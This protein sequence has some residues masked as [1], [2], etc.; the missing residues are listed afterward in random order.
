MYKSLHALVVGGEVTSP[1]PDDQ[2]QQ[3]HL[4]ELPSLLQREPGWVYLRNVLEG[5]IPFTK[6][7]SGS[8]LLT[9][10]A[11]LLILHGRDVASGRQSE[12]RLTRVGCAEGVVEYRL[13]GEEWSP[14]RGGKMRLYVSYLPTRR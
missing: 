8:F 9:A 7:M 6:L 13:V 1:Y 3:I 11:D 12:L 2:P 14:L 5:F 10:D 4:S